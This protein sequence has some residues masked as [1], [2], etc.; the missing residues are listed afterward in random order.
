LNK[1]NDLVDLS[2]NVIN[3]KSDLY[4]FAWKSKYNDPDKFL[5]PLFY[6]K[7]EIGTI[8]LSSFDD[9]KIDTMLDRASKIP[10]D[11]FRKNIYIDIDK[12]LVEKAPWIFLYQ[13][14]NYVLFKPNVYN[15]RFHPVLGQDLKNLYISD[16]LASK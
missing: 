3:K 13:P 5:S 2:N 12:Y 6:S 8:N 1:T 15:Y 11:E 9:K 16:N 4:H 14:V 7:K 10:A